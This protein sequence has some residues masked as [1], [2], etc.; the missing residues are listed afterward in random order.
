[1]PITQIHDDVPCSDCSDF[2]HGIE[3][4]AQLYVYV[5]DYFS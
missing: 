2:G 4:K 3:S 5:V 1:M